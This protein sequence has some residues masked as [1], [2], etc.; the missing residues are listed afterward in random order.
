MMEIVK[1]DLKSDVSKLSIYEG[2]YEIHI[3]KNIVLDN[4]CSDGFRIV[5]NFD[6]P[7]PE[8]G[9]DREVVLAEWAMVESIYIQALEKVHKDKSLTFDG[10][11]FDC[12]GDGMSTISNITKKHVEIGAQDLSYCVDIARKDLDKFIKGIKLLK[13]MFNNG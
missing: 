1:L 6:K 9:R 7:D 2:E 4:F 10:I 11:Y 8:S 12:L 13:A 3:T 5:V